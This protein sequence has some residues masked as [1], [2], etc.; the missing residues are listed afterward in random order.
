MSSKTDEVLAKINEGNEELLPRRINFVAAT[1][2]YTLQ[3]TESIVFAEST[4]HYSICF[5]G[6]KNKSHSGRSTIYDSKKLESIKDW[7]SQFPVGNGFI[8]QMNRGFAISV[9]YSLKSC[10]IFRQY[11]N[12]HKPNCKRVGC[13][14]CK[15][16]RFFEEIEKKLSPVFPL[17]LNVF[18]RSWKTGSYGDSAD[19][20]CRLLDL[21]QEEELGGGRAFSSFDKYTTAIGQIFR[22]TMKEKIICESCKRT[23]VATSSCWNLISADGIDKVINAETIYPIENASCDACQQEVYLKEEFTQLPYILTIHISHWSPDGQF[24]RKKF[25]AEKYNEITVSEVEYKLCA[26]TAYDGKTD[27]G[28]KF[29]SVFLSSSRTWNAHINGKI[30]AISSSELGNYYPQ[31]LFYTRNEQNIIIEEK[32]EIFQITSIEPEDESSDDQVER[33]K[34]ENRAADELRDS[35]EKQLNKKNHPKE[36][37]IVVDTTNVKARKV[38]KSQ[39]SKP[40]KSPLQKLIKSKQIIHKTAKWDGVEADDRTPYTS[41][42]KEE[43]PDEWDQEL[44]QGHVRKIKNKREAP[45]VNPFDAVPDKRKPEDPRG[46]RDFKSTGKCQFD[47][48]RRKSDDFRGKF[49]KKPFKKRWNGNKR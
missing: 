38:D 30:I 13:T 47:K 44:D 33:E 24:R 4:S 7:A 27:T 31:V 22:I 28:G 1:K 6:P 37:V 5:G 46:R 20:L 34:N 25:N 43:K 49:D 26:F 17:D 19:F 29:L 11:G 9:L 42:W 15:I 32:S 39:V 45:I 16:V 41:S 12:I 21:L 40:T 14:L 36:D 48:D 23:R 3:V 35:I 18:D 10:P 8:D 2:K